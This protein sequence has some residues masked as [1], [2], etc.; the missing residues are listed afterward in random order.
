MKFG[1]KTININPEKPVKQAGFIQQIDPI[2]EVHDDLHAR[3]MVL[4]EKQFVVMISTDNIGTSLEFQEEVAA[5]VSKRLNEEVDLVISA[6]HTHFGA[7]PLD[8]DYSDLLFNK[9]VEG[10]I[11][12]ELVEY[13]ELTYSYQFQPFK[14]VGKSRISKQ[15][16]DLVFIE[17]VSIFGD[18]KRLANLMIHNCHPTI[19]SGHTKFFSAEYPGYAIAKLSKHH[20]GEFFTFMQGADG[21]VST[22]FTRPSQTYDAV[23]TLGNIFVE[24]IEEMLDNQVNKKAIHLLYTKEVLS[25]V[26]EVLDL[27]TLEIPNDLDDRELETIEYGKLAREKVLENL[28]KLPKSILISRISFGEYHMIFAP[29]ELFSYYLKAINKDNASLVCY[30]NGF[31]KYV[32]GMEGQRI[33]YELFTDTYTMDTKKKMYNILVEMSK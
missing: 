24:K 6:T 31:G 20:Q 17:L 7:N 14:E 33:T 22:R 12:T 25:L 29:N 16:T 18:G 15:E 26:H 28:D 27:D 5:E 21:D 10:I 13:S 4:K 11:T 2:M 9:L 8:Q 30:S 3:I 1:A 23:E 19:M 32:T